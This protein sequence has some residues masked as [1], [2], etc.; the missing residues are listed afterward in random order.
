MNGRTVKRA[1]RA[2]IALGSNVGDREGYLALARE[3]LARLPQSTMI[4]A[5]AIE[6]T[7]PLGPIPQRHYLNQMVLLETGLT[8]RRLLERC[9]EIEQAAGRERAIR[10]GP[11]TL[12]LDI[13]SFGE[14]EVDE[15][16]LTIPH[17]GLPNREFWRREIAELESHV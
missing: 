14:R 1:E 11:R 12:D 5:S 3:E 13:V 8:P 16:G 7:T 10:W 15:P 6:E 4:A 9:L 17:P 2:Y